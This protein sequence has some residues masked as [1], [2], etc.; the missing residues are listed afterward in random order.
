[1]KKSIVVTAR[2]T[3]ALHK[4]LAAYAKAARRTKA[5]VIADILERYVDDEIAIVDAVNEGIRSAEEEGTIAHEEVFRRLKAKSVRYRRT[6]RK[7][8]A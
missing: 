6:H 7:Q 3:P 2:V 5:W 4:K 1:M 8:A